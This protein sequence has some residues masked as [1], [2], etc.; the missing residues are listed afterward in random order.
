MK[1]LYNKLMTVF[2]IIILQKFTNFRAIWSWSFQNICNEIGYGPVFF[3]PHCMYTV[4]KNEHF[5][6]LELCQISTNFNT[7]ESSASMSSQVMAAI[8]TTPT[9]HFMKKVVVWVW[10]AGH[11][12]LWC[13]HTTP[14]PQLFS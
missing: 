1:F 5:F 4:S 12:N 8:K 2:S 7:I 11:C 3:A 10:C 6:L 14:T 9:P 13:G